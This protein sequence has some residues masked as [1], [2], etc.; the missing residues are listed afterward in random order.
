MFGVGLS[1]LALPS[2]YGYEAEYDEYGSKGSPSVDLD[3]DSRGSWVDEMEADYRYES[4]YTQQKKKYFGALNILPSSP[5]T[6]HPLQTQSRSRRP[7]SN[8]LAVN[9]PTALSSGDS[10]Y[11]SVYAPGHPHPHGYAHP[12][13]V[14][15]SSYPGAASLSQSLPLPVPRSA[16][17]DIPLDNRRRSVGIIQY[18]QDI[19]NRYQQQRRTQ[20]QTPHEDEPW[21]EG[22]TGIGAT[23]TEEVEGDTDD[24]DVSHLLFSPPYPRAAEYLPH[25]YSIDFDL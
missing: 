5:K 6:V 2:S 11:A 4:E 23:H 9:V 1:N 8:P 19:I 16:P 22:G 24:G 12:V 13:S 18:E 3:D 21:N 14:R 25:S 15:S 20:T 10:P 17:I 7:N